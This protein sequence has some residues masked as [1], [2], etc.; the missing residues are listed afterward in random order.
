MPE[1][2]PVREVAPLPPAVPALPAIPGVDVA[3]G[4][5]AVG[6][7]LPLYTKLLATFGGQL[8]DLDG[9]L[10][11]AIVGADW[12]AAARAAHAIKGAAR[13]LGAN[14]IGDRAA[15]VEAAARDASADPLDAIEALRTAAHRLRPALA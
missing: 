4:L 3:A 2:E 5:A 6:G 15:S 7:K 13:T 9:E 12:S 14:E 11:L 1:K 10:L 8:D